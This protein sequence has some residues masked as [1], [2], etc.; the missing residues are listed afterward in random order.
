MEKTLHINTLID[1]NEKDIEIYRCLV[2]LEKDAC[3]Y[4]IVQKNVKL[5]LSEFGKHEYFMVQNYG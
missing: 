4:K 1:L 3:M 2:L 5:E